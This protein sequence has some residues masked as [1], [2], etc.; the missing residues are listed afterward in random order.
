[1]KG[2]NALKLYKTHKK[3]KKRKCDIKSG[4]GGER[5][6]RRG[7]CFVSFSGTIFPLKKAVIFLDFSLPQAYIC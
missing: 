1:V 6:W 4:N 2:Y 3:R 7:I 5:K